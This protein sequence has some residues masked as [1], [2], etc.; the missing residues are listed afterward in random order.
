MQKIAWIIKSNINSDD[1]WEY[2]EIDIISLTTV[3][4]PDQ[5]MVGIALQGVIDLVEQVIDRLV[6]L[7]SQA[8]HGVDDMMH[9]TED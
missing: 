1:F 5:G 6:A 4:I 2:T 9:Q 7:P 8:G 3:K